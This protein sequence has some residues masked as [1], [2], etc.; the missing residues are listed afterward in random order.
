M[1]TVS[2]SGSPRENVG[3]KDAKAIRAEKRVPCV[4]YGGEEQAH[5]SVDLAEFAKYVYTADVF[6]FEIDLDGNK[7][8]AIL[9]DLQFDPVTDRIIHA[10][11]LEI[12]EGKPVRME[13]PMHVTGNSIGVKNGGRLATNFRRI[14]V[15]GLPKDF[16]DYIEMDITPLRIGMSLRIRDIDLPNVTLLHNDDS[17]VVGVRTARGAIEDELEDEEDEEGEEGEGEEGETSEG[18]GEKS[19]EKAEE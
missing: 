8:E 7:V 5:F 10:D 19:Q 3:K 13:I 15:L 18:E 1:K 16:P 4:I 12:L 17:V 6:K 2:L 11:F 14:K 9:K